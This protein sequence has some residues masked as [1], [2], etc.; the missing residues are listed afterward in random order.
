MTDQVIADLDGLKARV[1]TTWMAGDYAR[2]AAFT[3]TAANEFIDRR[4]IKPGMRVLDVACGSGNLAIPAA[5]A[6][7]I[8]TGVLTSLPTCSPRP[9]SERKPRSQHHI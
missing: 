4:E 1:R 8:V 6:G 2:I 5:R 9:R 7:A 3:E